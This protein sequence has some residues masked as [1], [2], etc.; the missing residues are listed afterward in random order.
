MKFKLLDKELTVSPATLRQIHHL[1][2]EVGNVEKLTQDAP[3]DTIV[4]MM[5][6]ILKHNP[7]EINLD[8]ILD[9]CSMNELKVLNEAVAY[10]LGAN[11]QE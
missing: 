10:F 2:Q 8:W 11:A 1:E 6:V 5:G 3:F 9:N 4:K 7:Q